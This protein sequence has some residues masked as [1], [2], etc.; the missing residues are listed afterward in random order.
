M[1]KK[2]CPIIFNLCFIGNYVLQDAIVVLRFPRQ[3]GSSVRIGEELPGLP[4]H[5]LE[6]ID[7]D[8]AADRL[9]RPF[10]SSSYGAEEGRIIL[11]I[12]H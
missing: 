9:D 2:S 8:G 5:H 7:T 10:G 12:L 3:L 1:L 6:D 4:I 11:P